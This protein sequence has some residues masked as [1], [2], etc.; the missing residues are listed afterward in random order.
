[1]STSV[2]QNTLIRSKDKPEQ[3]IVQVKAKV[4]PILDKSFHKSST[5]CMMHLSL[6]KSVI[7]GL[8]E[9]RYIEE[10][11]PGTNLPTD[12]KEAQSTKQ[13]KL[14]NKPTSYQSIKQR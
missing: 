12:Q 4:S 9:P 13:S 14:L 6:S 3:A 8:K 10:E 5:T 11:T 2:G 7:T 1:M